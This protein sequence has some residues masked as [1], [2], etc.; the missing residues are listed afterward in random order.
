MFQAFKA[1]NILK[2]FIPEGKTVVDISHQKRQLPGQLE[3]LPVQVEAYD[4][5]KPPFDEFNCQGTF[6]GWDVQRL[7]GPPAF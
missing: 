4:V 7:A 3:T 1:K 6:S 5:G 2:R